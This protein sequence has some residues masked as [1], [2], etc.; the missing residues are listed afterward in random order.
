MDFKNALISKGLNVEIVKSLF[1]ENLNK[2]AFKKPTDYA[3]ENSRQKS[4]AVANILKVCSF[5]LTCIQ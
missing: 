3:V 5:M 2:N 4:I 1:E